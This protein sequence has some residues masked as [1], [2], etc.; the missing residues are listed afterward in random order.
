MKLGSERMRLELQR[1]VRPVVLLLLLALC[2][3]VAGWVIF[4]NQLFYRPWNSHI[5]ARAQVADAKGLVPGKQEVRIAGV[6]VGIVRKVE[7]VGDGAVVT[8]AL[9]ERY[10]PIYRNARIR[11]RPVT[12]LQDLYLALER[13]DPSAGRLEEGA[14]IPVEQTTTP[15]D[16]SRVLQTFDADTRERLATLLDELGR[17]LPDQGAELRATFAEVAPFLRSAQGVAEALSERRRNLR[18]L[19]SNF[20]DL[21]DALALNDR[22]LTLLVRNG[23]GTLAELARRDAPLAE[24]I[25]GIPPTLTSL[26]TSFTSLTRAEGE[27]D[28]ALDEL[29]P[30]ARRLPGGLAGLRAFADDARPALRDLRPAV[31]D[32]RPLAAQLAPTSRSLVPALRRLNRQ[33][34]SYDKL[35]G[36]LVPCYD[37]INR[38]FGDTLSV[39][40]FGDS[41]QAYPRGDLT[42]G[43]DSGGGNTDTGLRK[44]QFC[45][46]P[47]QDLGGGR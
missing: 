16:I 8:F 3:G 19:V 20:T 43:Y 34:P 4:K 27:L 39:T 9:Q 44:V 45:I 22:L 12:P 7:P 5:E 21:T 29:G 40:K 30:V 38:F 18:S 37:R 32:L 23:N 10:G 17:G 2:G 42:F 15:V 14:T 24:T 26:R 36:Q 41:F 46:P 28:P 25:R 6:R 13:G 11:I 47:L 33:A 31:R 35:T 1:S